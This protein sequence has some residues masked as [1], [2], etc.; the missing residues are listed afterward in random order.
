[1]KKNY[2]GGKI[3]YDNT[4]FALH[5]WTGIDLCDRITFHTFDIGGKAMSKPSEFVEW[6][7]FYKNSPNDKIHQSMDGNYDFIN[8]FELKFAENGI[9]VY[10][11]KK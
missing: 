3:L 11:R 9:V 1:M 8:N 10:K 2:K 6:V 7:I 4:V 5:P